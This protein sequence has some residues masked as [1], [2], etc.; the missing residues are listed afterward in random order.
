MT[1]QHLRSIVISHQASPKFLTNLEGDALREIWGALDGLLSPVGLISLTFPEAFNPGI[2]SDLKALKAAI[3]REFERRADIENKKPGRQKRT[4]KES[5]RC[6]ALY[7]FYLQKKGLYPE[8]PHGGQTKEKNIQELTAKLNVSA[9]RFEQVYNKVSTD[10]KERTSPEHIKHLS[11]AIEL[12]AEN[13]E[14]EAAKA[15]AQDELN[16]ATSKKR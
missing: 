9:Q 12:L 15:I 6:Y 11:R 5:Q 10:Q 1:V 16:I 14:H 8:F 7:Y 13:P 3:E 2:T 4:G